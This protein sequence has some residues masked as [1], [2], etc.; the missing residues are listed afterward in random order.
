MR[1][2][3][4]VPM[5]F[6]FRRSRNGRTPKSPG[7][8]WY[9][10]RIDGIFFHIT[11][12]RRIGSGLRRLLWLAYHTFRSCS[13]C[14]E[15]TLN[16]RNT[17]HRLLYLTYLRRSCRKP[18]LH[19]RSRPSWTVWR[20]FQHT[21]RVFSSVSLKILLFGTV[22]Q[23]VEERTKSIYRRP[24]K[25][26]VSWVIIHCNIKHIERSFGR[27]VYGSRSHYGVQWREHIRNRRRPPAT[28]G[29]RQPKPLVHNR[30][31]V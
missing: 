13:K 26:Q 2:A 23:L 17:S 14:L 6:C 5:L 29:R 28:T 25:I 19:H 18:H 8:Y 24:F 20:Y 4:R 30:V 10:I 15:E 9:H 21:S 11:L 27:E 1:A 7:D 31:L 16:R 22:S 3:K 12:V